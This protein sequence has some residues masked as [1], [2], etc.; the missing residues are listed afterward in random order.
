MPTV[1]LY[2][3]PQLQRAPLRGGENAAHATP[4]AFGA[5]QAQQS[6]QLGQS[7]AIAGQALQ[8]I[9]FG[10]DKALADTTDA[11]VRRGWREFD[12]E[13]RQKYQGNNIGDYEAAAKK[14]WADAPTAYGKDLTPQAKAIAS[15]S[16]ESA[17]TQAMTSALTHVA[18]VTDNNQQVAFVNNAK[19]VIDDAAR[20]GTP[21]A[22]DVARVQLMKSVSERAA[23]KGWDDATRNQVMS[24]F[25]TEM[26]VGY[27]KKLMNSDPTAAATYLDQAKAQG[28]LNEKVYNELTPQVEAHAAV[29]DGQQGAREDITKLTAE[30]KPYEAFP[31]ERLDAEG[32]KRFANNPK[33]LEA[34]RN[35]LDRANVLHTQAVAKVEAGAVKAV[36]DDYNKG[37]TLARLKLTDSWK[38]MSPDKQNAMAEHIQDR[39]HMLMLRGDADR[40][41][42]ELTLQRKF[43]PLMVAMSQPDALKQQTQESIMAMLPNIGAANVDHLLKTLNQYNSN[44]AK[45]SEA[46]IDNDS[47][48][49]ALSAAGKDPKPSH[50][51]QEAARLVVD[52]RSQVEQAVGKL[53][54]SRNKELTREEKDAEIKRVVNAKVFTSNWYGGASEVNQI[55]LTPDQ[56]KNAGVMVQRPVTNT[57]SGQKQMKEVLLRV[58]DVPTA[59][60]ADTQ[61][62]LRAKGLPSDTAAVLQRWNK[63]NN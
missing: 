22:L 28:F 63:A 53:Q 30:A 3:S 21:G 40:Q 42:A 62:Y 39:N 31:Q 46:K 12:M 6:A 52:L 7:L 57:G 55:D 19:E 15:K 14:W 59:E 5:V 9:N 45:F 54:Q 33:A 50:N 25:N 44:Q 1:P 48:N 11:A 34:Y 27:V 23:I 4:D 32:V 29:T 35:E 10:N 60:F 38:A 37:T 51:N 8:N 16:L 24:G 20:Q 13:A 18:T 47:F 49:A 17:Q 36:Y 58:S 61:R 41:H 43:A 26:V 56:L 2:D